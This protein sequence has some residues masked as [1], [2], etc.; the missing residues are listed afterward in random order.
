MNSRRKNQNVEDDSV[1]DPVDSDDETGPKRK[2]LHK[3]SKLSND[4]RTRKLIVSSFL[5]T[6]AQVGD[7]DDDDE[8][9]EDDFILPDESTEAERLEHNHK[10]RRLQEGTLR[11]ERRIGGTGHLVSA[12]DKLAKRYQDQTFEEGEDVDLFDDG[13][14][15][16]YEETSALLPDFSDPKLWIVKVNRERSARE[17]AISLQNKFVKMQLS[18]K[19]FG[20]YSCFAP[21]GVS[22]FLY[23]E[24]DTKAQ[25]IEALA[26]YRG[27]NPTTIKMIPLNEMASVFGLNVDQIQMPMVGDYVRVRM[28]R[29][30]GDLGQVVEIDELVGIATIRVIPR[31][32]PGILLLHDEEEEP[33]LELLNNSP[34]KAG[35][36]QKQRFEKRFFDRERIELKGGLIEQGLVPGTFRYQSMIFQESGH[37]LM[38]MRVNRLIVGEAVAVSL[39]E[40]KEFNVDK[41]QGLLQDP[42]TLKAT[43]KILHLYKLGER[44]RILR[45]E[46][47]NVIGKVSSVENDEI[48]VTPEKEEIPSFKIH[49]SCVIKHFVEGDNV[50]AIEG[51]NKGQVGLIALVDMKRKSAVVFNP[52]TGQEFKCGF[53]YLTLVP[54]EGVGT[55]SNRVITL[56]GYSIGDLVQTTFGLVGVISHIERSGTFAILG[57]DGA[58]HSVSSAQVVCK[59]HC[60]GQVARDY[61]Q[62]PVEVR[63]KVVV[64]NGKNKQKS[65]IVTHIWKRTLFIKTES[66]HFLSASA[67]NC[68]SS[69]IAANTDFGTPP[70]SQ[71]SAVLKTRRMP[72][73][74]PFIG[75]TVRIC[76]QGREKGSL[77]DIVGVEPKHFTISLKKKVKTIR[78]QRQDVV[79]LDDWD[80]ELRRRSLGVPLASR[81]TE[82]PDA[83]VN[84]SIQKP[85]WAQRGVVVHVV[86]AG[87]YYG[88]NG[89]ILEVID[90]RPDNNHMLVVHLAIDNDDYIAIALESVEPILPKAAGD[91]VL[92]YMRPQIDQ[93]ATVLK[94]DHNVSDE[95]TH[96]AMA[97]LHARQSG[98]VYQEPTTQCALYRMDV[99]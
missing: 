4:Q 18:G 22:G 51:L 62:Q 60:V 66:G 6:E 74:S 48:E 59:R 29:Y 78:C 99:K 5:D 24:A 11:D 79:I 58:E 13:E 50:R 90:A 3:S 33:S 85:V 96:T 61:N 52:S 71:G 15:A 63:S 75:K 44:V 81:S 36:K 70:I 86:G 26:D 68:L 89:T 47:T 69:A 8:N 95:G 25:V 38:R 49:W 93:V 46:L 57:D 31:L 72:Q 82:S 9:Y 56:D 20:L 87:N 27:A 40:L 21:P 43:R 84:A 53:E 64:V 67:D 30:A 55:S 1:E 35:G 7:D 83:T 19:H 77:G 41:M 65:G 37:L 45:G 97:T 32:D 88:C 94:I 34:T 98:T 14:V 92:A 42:A 39:S 76:I 23:L 12:I 80:T 10:L 16:N 2:R 17:I 54:S 91:M 28:G 73:K